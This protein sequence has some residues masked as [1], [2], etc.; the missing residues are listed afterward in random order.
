MQELE[1]CAWLSDGCWRCSCDDQKL[2]EK[3]A[4]VGSGAL[5]FPTCFLPGASITVVALALVLVFVVLRT[6][7]GS[8]RRYR[9]CSSRRC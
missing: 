9:R 5:F 4:V 2:L 1:L 8:Y 7:F 6:S 3:L